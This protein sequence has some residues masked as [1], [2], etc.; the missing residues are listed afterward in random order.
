[1]TDILDTSFEDKEIEL[2]GNRVHVGEDVNIIAKDP[3]LRNLH[4]GFGWDVDNFNA[5]SLDLDVS[6]FLLDK[7]DQTREDADFI[8]YNNM[9]GCLGAIKHN[10]DNRTGAGDG[11]D[12]S[13]SI[14]LQGIPFDIMRLVF[15]ISIYQGHE[16]G[17]NMGMVT[18]GFIRLANADT[19]IEL[20]R[21]EL[22]T[23][24]EDRPETA[25]VV[26]HINREGP[27][28]HLVPK[29]DFIPGGLAEI[30]EHYGLIIAKQ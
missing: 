19:G 18:N 1:M 23:V 12:E 22:D 21:Y 27:K 30:A 6:L 28:W 15:V 7:T 8:F 14:D 20:M 3:T 4:V 29:N 24:L 10:G 26:A 2:D 13:M 25:M 16:K 11:D 17:Q 5:D 9:E